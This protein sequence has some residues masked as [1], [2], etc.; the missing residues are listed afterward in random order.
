[1]AFE[2]TSEQVLERNCASLQLT[3]YDQ[4]GTPGCVYA[5]WFAPRNIKTFEA[6]TY[7]MFS[8]TQVESLFRRIVVKPSMPR[9]SCSL[10]TNGSKT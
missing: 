10:R 5:A 1:M 4:S 2:L 9:H 8:E 7:S 6:L 3:S